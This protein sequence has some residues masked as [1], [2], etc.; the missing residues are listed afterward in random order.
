MDAYKSEAEAR[1]QYTV[2]PGEKSQGFYPKFYYTY[3]Q[4]YISPED[5]EEIPEVLGKALFM[6]LPSKVRDNK[7]VV[8][9]NNNLAVM[10]YDWTYRCAT[11]DKIRGLSGRGYPKAHIL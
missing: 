4:A 10:F 9:Y 7:I 1:K 11:P 8:V 3:E 2:P 6:A 5:G